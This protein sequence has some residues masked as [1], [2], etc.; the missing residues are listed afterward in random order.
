MRNKLTTLLT[1]TT[2]LVSQSA[3]YSG[4]IIDKT[5][6]EKLESSVDPQEVVTVYG[7]CPSSSVSSLEELGALYAQADEAPA[8]GG[9]EGE[10]TVDDDVMSEIEDITG[11]GTATDADTTPEGTKAPANTGKTSAGGEKATAGAR[12]GCTEVNVS[13]S[14]SLQ[15]I[16][17]DGRERVTPFNFI[18]SGG[19]LVSPEYNLLLQLDDV[20]GARVREFSTFKTVAAIA[21]VSAVAVGTFVAITLFA[22]ESEGFAP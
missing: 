6:L 11:E 7:D 22:P 8:E 9:T 3:C 13:A 19:Q 20:E 15:L 14:N 16:T 18:M 12:P 21:L 10:G 4:Y 5:E 17:T 2:F 1:V